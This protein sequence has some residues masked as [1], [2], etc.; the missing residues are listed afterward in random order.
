MSNAL[1]V[2][3]QQFAD[4][5][6]QIADLIEA[7]EEI[8]LPEPRLAYCGVDSKGQLAAVVRALGCVEK[9]WSIDSLVQI[10]RMFGPIALEY[11]GSRY[12]IC[13][14]VQVGTKL[15]EAE[16][17]RIVPATEAR[18]VPIYEFHCGPL[19]SDPEAA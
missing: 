15:V 14:R 19:L 3:H 12:N 4:G 7:H 2:T 13:E 10:R 16:P 6:R 9:D 11:I 18:E 5:L 8:P 1:E 17:Q